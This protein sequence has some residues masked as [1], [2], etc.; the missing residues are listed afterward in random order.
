MPG[1]RVA[2]AEG[3]PGKPWRNN[4]CCRYRKTR[5]DPAGHRRLPSKVDHQLEPSVAWR[6]GN[7]RDEAYTGSVWAVRLS[8]ERPWCGGRRRL[9]NGRLYP[10]GCMVWPVAPPG[11][12]NRA[13]TRGLPRNLGGPSLLREE[14]WKPDGRDRSGVASA[15]IRAMDEANNE[16]N[17]VPRAEATRRV[18]TSD[19]TSER[20][21]V[22][23]KPGNQNSLGLGGGKGSAGTRNRWR[24]RWKA[25][26]G[27]KLSQ[28]NKSE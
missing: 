14:R 9:P 27:H 7:R 16:C 11:S 8:P 2:G 10:T 24:A 28:R 3:A 17:A 4:R 18:G 19:R 23:L 13:R 22:P 6:P 1:G 25:H 15:C 26:Q 20:L 12:E 21:V 5:S